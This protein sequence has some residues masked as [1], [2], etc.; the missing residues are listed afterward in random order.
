MRYD[1][2]DERTTLSSRS[3]LLLR[4][5]KKFEI[6]FRNAF[7]ES[8]EGA[9]AEE[10]GITKGSGRAEWDKEAKRWIHPPT[11]R[12]GR[13]GRMD[14]VVTFDDP[15]TGLPAKLVIELKNTDWDKI[16]AKNVRRNLSRHRIQ[17]WSYLEPLSDRADN[18][19]LSFIQGVIVYPKRPTTS[20][21]AE[22]I[23]DELEEWGISVSWDD[24]PRPASA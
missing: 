9:F 19:E 6:D 3:P 18:D 13:R 10:A 5:G 22:E 12:R 4:L 23:E 15:E 11:R 8:A 7:V 24:H 1:S 21:R 16:K 17:I 14:L 2:I 20:G